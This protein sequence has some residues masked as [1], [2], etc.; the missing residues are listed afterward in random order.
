MLALLTVKGPP[1]LSILSTWADCP[2]CC[3]LSVHTSSPPPP[4][5]P[6]SPAL[7]WCTDFLFREGK[8]VCYA[9]EFQRK[10]HDPSLPLL[11]FVRQNNRSLSPRGSVCPPSRRPAPAR[12][13]WK[14]QISFVVM[15]ME[16]DTNIDLESDK[17][18]HRKVFTVLNKCARTSLS[19]GSFDG[20]YIEIVELCTFN[21]LKTTKHVK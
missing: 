7:C 20:I 18:E 3:L 2:P 19:S 21:I 10:G 6:L 8:P 12:V 13:P 15:I 16:A 17:A 5:L 11:Q 9:G 1:D 14:L 4:S